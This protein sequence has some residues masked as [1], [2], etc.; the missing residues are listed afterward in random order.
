MTAGAAEPAYSG[1][2]SGGYFHDRK[3][4]GVFIKQ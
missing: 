1:G 2:L 4:E 3:V